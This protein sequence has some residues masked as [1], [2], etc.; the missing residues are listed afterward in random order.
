MK[1]LLYI[2]PVLALLAACSKSEAE[3]PLDL[4][5]LSTQALSDMAGERA[6][7]A[8]ATVKQDAE[9]AVYL[10]LNDST[11]T[12]PLNYGRPYEGLC[13]IFCQLSRPNDKS[14]CYIYWMFEIER[15]ETVLQDPAT[16]SGGGAIPVGLDI[17]DD[18]TTSVEDGFLTV[19]Y[20]AWWGEGKVPHTLRLYRSPG[21][22]NTFELTLLHFDNGD[23][24]LEKADALVCFDIDPLL[25]P[26]QGEYRTLTLKWT[27]LE[28]KAASKEFKYRSRQ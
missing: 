21:Q 20:S 22:E 11:R 27:T 26:T 6:I 5:K 23:T 14:E 2:L 16:A 12:Y 4:E 8:I 15:G 28:G 1:R 9:G 13:R 3:A 18:W 24:A 10:Q 19:H 25:T 7:N 17:L